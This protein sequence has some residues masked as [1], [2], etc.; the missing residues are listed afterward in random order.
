MTTPYRKDDTVR[1]TAEV[2]VDDPKCDE[3]KFPTVI[4]ED[5]HSGNM[6]CT[7]CGLVLEGRMILDA[8]SWDMYRCG[9]LEN[10]DT[11]LR[12]TVSTVK[13]PQDQADQMIY[14][15]CNHLQLSLVIMNRAKHIIM[16]LLKEKPDLRKSESLMLA[17][18]YLACKGE[19]YPCFYE[20]LETASTRKESIQ[21]S[22]GKI[23]K[24]KC[25][26]DLMQTEKKKES[27]SFDAKLDLHCKNLNLPVVSR[28]VKVCLL[29]L[30]SSLCSL[31]NK[32]PSFSKYTNG[33]KSQR[34]ELELDLRR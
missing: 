27:P 14:R 2:I 25:Y 22:V 17:C 20:K 15:L 19:N 26:H 33:S 30:H 31:R 8:A 18:I 16:T 12:T 4:V 23:E 5:H 28:C 32:R 1:T 3:C 13:T 6:I 24:M 29:I 11:V 34:L 21:R 9:G 7:A 10:P